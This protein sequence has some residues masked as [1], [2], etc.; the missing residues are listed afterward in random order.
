MST[1]ADQGRFLFLSLPLLAQRRCLDT[2]RGLSLAPF[3][4]AKKAVSGSRRPI[5]RSRLL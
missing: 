4:V 5:P 1:G 3:A 2:A